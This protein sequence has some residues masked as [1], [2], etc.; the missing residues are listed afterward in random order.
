MIEV[1]S[2]CSKEELVF[3]HPNVRSLPVAVLTSSPTIRLSFYTVCI[4]S[5]RWSWLVR[6]LIE[7]RREKLLACP[8]PVVVVV[9]VAQALAA[10]APSPSPSRSSL[11]AL[12]STLCFLLPVCVVAHSDTPDGEQA[13][14]SSAKCS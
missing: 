4:L 10:F 8:L 3:Q 9:A 6:S 7:E 11:F 1:A 2:L 14:N 5:A 13:S 12:H